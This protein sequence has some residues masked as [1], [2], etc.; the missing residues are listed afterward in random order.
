MYNF[1]YYEKLKGTDKAYLFKFEVP[2]ELIYKYNLK[3]NMHFS[4]FLPKSNCS[5]D[6]QEKTVGIPEW[7]FDKWRNNCEEND[8]IVYDK[9]NCEFRINKHDLLEPLK[10]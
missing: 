2:K 6:Y 1:T 3:L 10:N 5:Y 8:A 4:L 7:M 9:N